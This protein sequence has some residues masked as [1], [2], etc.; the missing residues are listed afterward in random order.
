VPVD[1]DETL[2]KAEKLVKQGKLAA[3]IKEYVRLVEDRPGDW[4]TVN[5]LG[6][7]YVKAGDAERAV[8]QF[9]RAADHLHGEGFFPR[10]SALYKKVLKVRGNDDHALWQLADIAGRNGLT[11]DARAHYG[12]IIQDRRAAGNEQGAVDCLI[13]LGRLGD[14]NVE[15]RMVAANALVERGESRQAARLMLSVAELLTKD[16]LL[17]EALSALREAARLDPED[18]EIRDKL[19]KAMPVENAGP[20]AQHAVAAIEEAPEIEQLAVVEESPAVEEPTPIEKPRL[21]APEPGPGEAA[22]EP[23]PLESFFEELRGKVA[24]DQEM[25][26]REHLERGIEYLADNK[27]DE[28]ITSFDQASR[29][30]A[31]RFEASSHL[32]RLLLVRGDLQAAVDWMERA[33]EAPA[34]AVEDRLGIMYD[35]AD[36]LVRQGEAS[37]AMALFMELDA[38]S[39][40]YRNVR[41]R[42]AQLSHTEIGNP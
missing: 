2:K 15:A 36:T 24:R 17:P 38:E 13:R 33:L 26:A 1:R 19:A 31:F 32:A 10:A 30:P 8:E 7:L 37:R 9:T 23:L 42:I 29:T 41:E 21:T 14:A 18:Q 5:A 12:R 20:P 40:G 6:D 11:L 39:S 34:P 16:G 3:A 4:N 35:L 22:E 25:R 27:V 28:A